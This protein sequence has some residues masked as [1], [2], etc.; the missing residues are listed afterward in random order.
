MSRRAGELA[1]LYLLGTNTYN[2]NN[3]NKK[4]SATT[5]TKQ[6]TA[7]GKRASASRRQQHKKAPPPPSLPPCLPPS[8]SLS[9]V[10]T[11]VL[12]LRR[13]RTTRRPSPLLRPAT[14][15]LSSCQSAAQSFSH[16]VR[17]SPSSSSSPPFPQSIFCSL[18]AA[19]FSGL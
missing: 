10:V 15:R 9:P 13:R 12:T 4:S 19:L 11:F 8:L 6:I 17:Q 16:F 3:K 5:T 18:F 7:A 1:A 14:P 2:N